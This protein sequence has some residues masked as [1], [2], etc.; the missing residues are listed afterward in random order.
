L[1]A[2]QVAGLRAAMDQVYGVEGTGE[3]DGPA[4]SSYMQNKVAGLDLCLTHARV[5]AAIC[6]VLDGHIKS[7]GIHGRP[8]PPGGEQQKLHVDYNGPPPERRRF[9]VCN[10][11]WML[12]DF[13]VDNGATRVVPGTH[14]SGQ[15]P[16][17]LDDPAADHPDQI[18]C[19]GQAGDVVVFNSH[20][21]HGTTRNRSDHSRHSLTSFYCRRDDPH[22][23]F[24]SALSAEA[25]ER[26]SEP[27]RC[28]F[29]DPEPW[30]P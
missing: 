23:V 5:L 24:S 11:V 19:A 4:E 6:H 26:L 15:A 22:M 17:V 29:A 16:D 13:T 8:H 12:T 30:T 1:T 9:A 25:T 3:K 14:L 18:V 20:T 2:A 10:S 27:A 21:W 28:L 7:F